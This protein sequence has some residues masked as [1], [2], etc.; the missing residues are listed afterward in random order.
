MATQMVSAEQNM[1]RLGYAEGLAIQGDWSASQKL[2]DAVS[3]NLFYI[4]INEWHRLN[5]DEKAL[6]TDVENKRD[7]VEKVLWREMEK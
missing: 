2:I 3:E 1:Y 7:R 6:W 5:A 4:I